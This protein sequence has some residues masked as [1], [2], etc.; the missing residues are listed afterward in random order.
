MIDAAKEKYQIA[1]YDANVYAACRSDVIFGAPTSSSKENI[2]CADIPFY[3]MVF[4][5]YVPMICE[6]LN[7]AVD[8]NE[9]KLKAVE[10][11]AGLGFVVTDRYSN[12]FADSDSYYF[13]GSQ[14]A[15]LKKT[16]SA[17]LSELN[18]YYAA[19]AGEEIV[20]H[21]ILEN[22]LRLTEFSNQISVY[23]NYTEKPLPTPI[24]E[25]EPYGFIWGKS[26]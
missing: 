6:P 21:R 22:G 15:D 23:V 4:K 26:A 24:G 16:V 9:N 25:V 1:S 11:G 13:F 12:E 19:I 10:C 5:G 17:D 14:Y 7:L 2:F 8:G 20:G 3:E 18:D